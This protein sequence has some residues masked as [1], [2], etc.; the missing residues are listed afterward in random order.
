MKRTLLQPVF[1]ISCLLLFLH[2]VT[3]FYVAIEWIDNY[4]DD[5]V[6]MPIFLTLLLFERRHVFR[7]DPNYIFSWF[8]ISVIT[9]V[10][11]V[12]YEA[13]LPHYNTSF[14]SDNWDYLCYALGSLIF[15]W[16]TIPK[17]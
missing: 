14:T 10:F 16:S 1:V 4:L 7:I 5:L 12:F 8:E 9:L 3:Q 2:Q 6:C 13:I 15:G 17:E 11:G